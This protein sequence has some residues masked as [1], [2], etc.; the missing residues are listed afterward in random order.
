M[1]L[2]MFEPEVPVTAQPAEHSAASGVS[3]QKRNQERP[4]LLRASGPLTKIRHEEYYARQ[5]LL[6]N[7]PL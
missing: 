1:A 4:L 5:R 2:K 6:K 3:G 7:D